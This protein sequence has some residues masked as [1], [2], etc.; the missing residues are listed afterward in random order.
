MTIFMLLGSFTVYGSE[1]DKLRE[2]YSKPSQFW[3]EANIEKGVEFRELAVLPEVSFPEHNPFFKSKMKLGEKLFNDGRLSRSN[4]I[5]CASCHDGDL[6]WG[7]GRRSSFGHNRQKGSRNAP[8]I[9]NV[10]FNDNFF[11]DG[12]AATLEQQALMPIQDPLEMN[13]T[14]P[15]LEARLNQLPEYKEAF[16]QVF[17]DNKITAARIGKA[18]ATY[19]R[20][21]VSRRSDFDRLLTANQQKT[22][23][24]KKLYRNA[25]SDQAILGLHLFRTKARCINCHNGPTFS[26]QK[27]HN[28]GLTYYKRK[29]Q[30]LGLYNT[31]HKEDDV[32]KFKTPSLRGVMNT[33][34]WMHNGLFDDMVGI[35]RLYNV[36]GI[37]TKK[38]PDDPLSP[39]TSHILQPLSLNKQ[40]IDAL[41]EF[42]QAITAAPAV[43]PKTSIIS[44]HSEKK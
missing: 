12:R 7:D 24:L 1:V 35:L 22:D 15:E 32:G 21:I 14:L 42:L 11:W 37:Q 25:M 27:F 41:A 23:R 40:E 2:L 36:G 8:T 17:G 20:T 16:E 5:A 13:F 4:Q 19:Q 9:E 28:I 31:T 29:H 34:P 30:D 26:D 38:K 18:L 10:A 3:P 39:E 44:K 43:G 6:G 33:K